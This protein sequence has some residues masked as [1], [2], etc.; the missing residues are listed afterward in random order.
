[1]KLENIYFS[2]RDKT[3]Q[4]EILHNMS[5]TFEK[6]MFYFI[7]ARSGVG[8]STLLNICS[9][10]IK[11]DKGKVIVD[12]IDIYSLNDKDLSLLRLKKFGY[13]FQT[14]NLISTLTLFENIEYPLYLS[15]ISNRRAQVNAILKTLDIYSVANQRPDQVSGGQRQRTAI[16][17][18]LICKPEYIFADEPTANLD[19]EN[20]QI[21][22]NL[23]L[24][25]QNQVNTTVLYVTHDRDFVKLS[26]NRLV[27]SNKKLEVFNV[28]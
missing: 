3:I 28:D 19:E 24:D 7:F 23:I 4:S 2:Y 10:L 20:S 1:M 22:L 13:V 15:G 8:K 6:G 14:F 21:I 26:P 11:P 5:F 17:R 25:L 27:I 9:G 12:G 16:A 18:A